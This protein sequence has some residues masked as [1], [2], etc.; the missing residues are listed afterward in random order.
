M[1]IAS[2]IGFVE[3]KILSNLPGEH[4]LILSVFIAVVL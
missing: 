1:C 2:S 3:S 4:I